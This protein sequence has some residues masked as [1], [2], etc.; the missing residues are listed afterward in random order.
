[1]LWLWVA[2]VYLLLTGAALTFLYAAF[3]VAQRHDDG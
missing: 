3:T 1:M 2:L